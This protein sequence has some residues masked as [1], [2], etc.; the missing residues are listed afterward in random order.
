MQTKK[1]FLFAS[2]ALMGYA[3]NSQTVINIREN[4][5]ITSKE[6]QEVSSIKFSERNLLLRLTTGDVTSHAL[7]DI[8]KIDFT[9]ISSS[10]DVVLNK[11]ESTALIYPNPSTGNESLNLFF[12]SD[13]TSPI[14]LTIYGLDGTIK[15][16]KEFAPDGEAIFPFQLHNVP[17]GMYIA[18][19]RQGTLLKTSKFIIK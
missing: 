9:K 14:A 17:S 4:S 8:Q 3:A 19:V 15:T 11:E 18:V 16:Q 10:I 13:L 6:L 5:G 1:I 7:T 2:L 12:K